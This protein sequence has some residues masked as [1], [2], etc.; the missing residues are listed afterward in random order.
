MCGE[1]NDDDDIKP[2]LIYT[3]MDIFAMAL[4][5]ILNRHCI[6]VF[7]NGFV[8]LNISCTPFARYLHG[9]QCPLTE[10]MPSSTCANDQPVTLSDV[11]VCFFFFF[12]FF[13]CF[14]FFFD[15]KRPLSSK[16]KL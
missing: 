1:I 14:F 13:F 7:L 16:Y 2:F 12:V 4:L 5:E 10:T 15:P 9:S 11:F 8:S 6:D 3:N